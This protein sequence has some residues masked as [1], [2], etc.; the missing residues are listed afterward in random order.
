MRACTP[1]NGRLCDGSTSMSGGNAPRNFS[2]ERQIAGERVAVRL[3][4]LHADIGRNAAA[5]SGRRRS[6]RRSPR[7]KAGM[8][9]RM[10]LADQ[11]PPRPARRSR[12]RCPRRCGDR[13]AAPTARR[14]GNCPG[15]RRRSSLSSSS[16]PARRAKSRRWHG[17]VLAARRVH[18]RVQ[19]LLVG[20]PQGRLPTLGQPAGHADMVGM[21]MG[22]DDPPDRPAAEM[23]REDVLATPRWS[24]AA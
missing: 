12:S 5:G 19:P 8:L 9:R 1:R 21:V 14:G 10:P 13:P 6:R 17:G 2:S 3:V 24:R 7:K 4:G 16:S 22:D 20:D 11:H 23:R 18:A 15:A